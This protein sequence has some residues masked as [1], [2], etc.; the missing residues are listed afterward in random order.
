VMVHDQGEFLKSRV[1]MTI[2]PSF[3]HGTMRLPTVFARSPGGALPVAKECSPAR[4][5]HLHAA[6]GVG[7]ADALDLAGALL[8]LTRMTPS[9]STDIDD[10][11]VQEVVRSPPPGP[12]VLRRGALR[13]PMGTPAPYTRPRR[14]AMTAR[15]GPPYFITAVR[16]DTAWD[17]FS[18]RSRRG[19]SS[20]IVRIS[21]RCASLYGS[22]S[23]K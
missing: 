17:S 19:L 7:V 8:R 12:V 23:S 4:N 16:D 5:G 21:I 6:A 9:V 18:R 3:S 10:V 22:S 11:D 1:S 14:A 13:T 20:T 2:V 15:P